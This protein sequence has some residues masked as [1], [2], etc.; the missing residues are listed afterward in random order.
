MAQAA[1][2]NRQ[3]NATKPVGALCGASTKA[4]SPCRKP[5]GSGTDHV[6][7]GQCKLHLGSTQ[8]GVIHAAKL[9]AAAL[10]LE[11]Q[12]EPHVAILRALGQAAKWELICRLR[13]AD[14]R[15]DEYV[16]L[17]EKRKVELAPRIVN[18][19]DVDAFVGGV[20]DEDRSWV[21]ERTIEVST[22]AELNIWIREHQKAIAELARVGKVAVDAGVQERQIRMAEQLVGDLSAAIAGI[23][24]ELGVHDDKR[25]PSVVRKH[26]A[27][28][29]GGLAA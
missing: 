24:K 6:G 7:Y 12:I 19:S 20:A 29:E 15:D 25:A 11:H 9:E 27:L 21:A 4:G 26:L 28:L 1:S 14:L 22:V 16:V 2:R 10:G 17:H 5:A 8:R 3:S 13:V 23:L 18:D